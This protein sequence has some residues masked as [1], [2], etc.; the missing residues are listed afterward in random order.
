MIQCPRCGIQVTE[1]HPVDADLITK[2]QSIGEANLPPQVCAGC[3]SDLRRTVASSSGGILMA[4]ERAKEQ[5]RLQLWKS[6]VM[7]IKK[8]RLC[9]T[10]KLYS[11]AAM[12]YEKYL[13]ILD[14]VFDIK[15]GERLKPE[16]FKDSARTT[17]LTVV[18]SVYWDLMRIYD[19][20]EK[21]ADRMTNAAKQLAMFIQFTP[22]YPDIIRKAESFQKTA[23]NP[24]IVK[25]FLKM[26]DKERPRCFIATAAFENSQAPEVMSL[27]AF[28]DFTL[29]Q[30]AWGR[31]FIAIYYKFSPHIAC[32]LDKQPRMKP[33][34]RAL[35]R[36]LIKCVS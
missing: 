14:I 26:S 4:Q 8:A 6:R 3:I 20:H 15:K 5:H 23:R 16:A 35:L 10:Q 24:H 31:K 28:R 19:T 7:L 13:K 36:L 27:R 18:A 30:S 25:Q 29:R 2:L 12:S 33:A 32:L 11:E 1:L 34:V 9:M 22:I 17:E 21:Y